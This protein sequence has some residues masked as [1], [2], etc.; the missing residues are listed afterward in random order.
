[1]QSKQPAWKESHEGVFFFFFCVCVCVVCVAKPLMRDACCVRPVV[2][3]PREQ[4]GHYGKR[5][6]KKKKKKRKKEEEKQQQRRATHRASRENCRFL[7]PFGCLR[8]WLFDC[9]DTNCNVFTTEEEGRM[10]KDKEQ[11]NDAQDITGHTAV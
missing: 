9:Q 7:T 11:V 6:K 5:Q 3:L 10:K 4:A 2:A 8:W 1:M